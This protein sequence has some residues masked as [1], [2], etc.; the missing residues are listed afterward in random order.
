MKELQM[1]IPQ[2]FES[3]LLERDKKKMNKWIRENTNIQKAKRKT[4]EHDK[5]RQELD[6]RFKD[7]AKTMEYKSMVGCN[8]DVPTTKKKKTSGL[9]P[10]I[11]RLRR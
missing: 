5:S 6:K 4:R 10:C 3:Y 11:L 9:Q 7:V 8:D 1:E 2:N